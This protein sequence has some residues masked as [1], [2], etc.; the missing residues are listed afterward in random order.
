[1]CDKVIDRTGSVSEKQYRCKALIVGA[2]LAGAALGFLL[3]E[4]GD[5]VLLLE[6]LD[7]KEKDELCGGMTNATGV[8]EFEK[9]FGSNSFGANISRRRFL[10]GNDVPPCGGRDPTCER[11]EKITV[12]Y[13]I[14]D[15]EAWKYDIED[16]IITV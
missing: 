11:R 15:H 13:K 12:P 1:M 8:E 14:H 3:R 10:R 6:L 4:A 5:D 16:Y 9:I 2:G 7:A